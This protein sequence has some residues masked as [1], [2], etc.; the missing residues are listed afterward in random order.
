[1]KKSRLVRE[2]SWWVGL[3]LTKKLSLLTLALIL[4]ACAPRATPPTPIPIDSS[5][6]LTRG[7]N[8]VVLA[9]FLIP[10]VASS[11]R[12][13]GTN[14]GVNPKAPCTGNTTALLCKFGALKVGDK[15]TI[16]IRGVISSGEAILEHPDGRTR[17]LLSP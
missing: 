17:V 6:T 1:M 11:V 10:I 7:P 14:L 2:A 16:P 4:S 15:L 8:Q 5:A 9:D 3:M 13:V 12:F